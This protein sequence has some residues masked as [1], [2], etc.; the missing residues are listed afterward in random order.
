MIS[1]PQTI[2]FNGFSMVLGSFNHWFQWFSMVMDHWSKDTMV[3]MY[4]SPLLPSTN[5]LFYTFVESLR[6]ELS[7]QS[8]GRSKK[9]KE[10]KSKPRMSACCSL[11]LWK[12]DTKENKLL[13]L[14]WFE[15]FN[16]QCRGLSSSVAFEVPVRS[17]RPAWL[18]L[19][20]CVV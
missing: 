15:M 7:H 16:R 12:Y 13:N 9:T 4:R 6:G 20:D 8:H 5:K 19:G 11:Q 3:S 14:R 2:G 18:N 10:P 1:S 17:S